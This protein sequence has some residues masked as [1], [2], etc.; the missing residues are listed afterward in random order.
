MLGINA[1]IEPKP[2]PGDRADRFAIC[3]FKWLYPGSIQFLYYLS[4]QF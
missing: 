3:F 1:Q 4:R 2:A